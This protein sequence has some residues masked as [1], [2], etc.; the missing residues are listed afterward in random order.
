MRRIALLTFLLVL[1]AAP[2]ADAAKTIVVRGAG[3]GHGIGMSQYGAYGFA[4]QGFDYGQ[5]LRTTTAARRLG[6]APSRNVRVLLQ[7]SDRFV[8]FRGA[9]RGPGGVELDPS[10]TYKATRARGGKVKLTGGGERSAPSSR[11]CASRAA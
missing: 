10:I 6:E 4:Q 2:A 9:T 3:F 5:I 1:A 11:P 8:R 7:A